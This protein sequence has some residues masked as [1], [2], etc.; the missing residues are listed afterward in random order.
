M[1]KEMLLG[2]FSFFIAISAFSQARPGVVKTNEKA[3]RLDS[4]QDNWFFQIQAGPSFTFS[5]DFSKA[6]LGDIISPNVALSIGK[7]FAPTVGARLQVGGWQSR[8]YTHSIRE[9]HSRN[10]LQVSGD[11]MLNLSN[12]FVPFTQE[13]T[14]NVYALLGAAY[15]Y[16]F[17]NEDKNMSRLNSIVPRAGLQLDYRLSPMIS[18]NLEAMGNLM[19]DHFNGRATGTKYD[20]LLNVLVGATFRLGNQTMTETVDVGNPNEI[21]RLVNEVRSQQALVSERDA[22]LHSKNREIAALNAK[23]NSRPE[24]VVKEEEEIVMNAVVV[25]KIGRTELQD[26][27]EINIYNAA[28][29]FQENPNMDIIIT[30]YAD[31]AT[32]NPTL[33]QRLS[34]QRAEAVKRVMVNKYGIDSKRITTQGGGDK[35]QPFANDAWNRVAIFTAVPKRK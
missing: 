3:I 13:K 29:Y 23:L 14:F 21:N 26:N 22:T 16:G 8:S 30:G 7:H 19:D 34:E 35:V 24:V 11:F 5:E 1:K 10:Y 4:F 25:F 33:N 15:V 6:G 31:R 9:V 17:K 32:G 28:K 20:G 2:I 12:L 18:L 27:Q